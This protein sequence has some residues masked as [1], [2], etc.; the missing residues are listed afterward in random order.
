LPILPELSNK[1]PRAPVSQATSR[2]FYD[3]L[4]MDGKKIKIQK[5]SPPSTPAPKQLDDKD[6]EIDR[7]R[8]E[9]ESLKKENDQL[10]KETEVLKE[11]IKHL[12]KHK[13]AKPN[14][15]LQVKKGR[16]KIC[17]KKGPKA[18]RMLL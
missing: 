16:S 18:L 4:V 7:L 5:Q 11:E 13:W 8:I 9:N 1:F 17:P 14:K 2:S 6:L 3:F 12:N 10:K 15:K